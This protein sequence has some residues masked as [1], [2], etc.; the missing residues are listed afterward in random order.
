MRLENVLLHD[1]VVE[2]VL[3]LIYINKALTLQ[4]RRSKDCYTGSTQNDQ[5][6]P[7]GGYYDIPY[8]SYDSFCNFWGKP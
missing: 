3:G 7:F 2:K 6:N 5:Y 8:T 1:Q 4:V